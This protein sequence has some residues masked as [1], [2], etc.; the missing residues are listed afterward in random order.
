[1]NNKAILTGK[2][3]PGATVTAMTLTD[4]KGVEF[5]FEH[6]MINVKHGSPERT[7]HLAWTGVTGVTF[8]VVDGVATV[9]VT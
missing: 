5:D 1:M 6:S 7:F 9:T 4:V 8:A 3:G 2:T